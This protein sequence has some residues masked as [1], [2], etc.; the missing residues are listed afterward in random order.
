MR[1]S[2]S[3]RDCGG[4]IGLTTES[5]PHLT[6]AGGYVGSALPEYQGPYSVTPGASA[7]T[8]ATEGKA[9]TADVVI[10]P[11]P[12]NYGLITWTGSTLLVS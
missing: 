8:L 6:L 5:P 7:Q 12:S 9:M 4:R 10:A 2:L 3:I 11:I 1:V